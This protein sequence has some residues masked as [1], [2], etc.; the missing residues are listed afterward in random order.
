MNSLKG[1]QR[2]GIIVSVVWLLVI[3]TLSAF[4]LGFIGPEWHDYFAERATQAR[5]NQ[6]RSEASVHDTS[7]QIEQKCGFT[8]S[9][10]YGLKEA[11]LPSLAPIL[12]W[13]F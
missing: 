13:L 10:A 11:P 2:L 3:S 9:E 1:W 12:S 4:G 7:D 8:F 5:I 6:C